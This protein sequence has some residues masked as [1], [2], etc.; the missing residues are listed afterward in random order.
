MFGEIM[1]LLA[2]E[3]FAGLTDVTCLHFVESEE[4]VTMGTL[5][6]GGTH[7]F[8]LFGSLGSFPV[9]GGTHVMVI[10]ALLTKKCVTGLW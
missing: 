4:S 10:Q 3:A 9:G 6:Y 5:A 8:D 1:I 7:R 2:R